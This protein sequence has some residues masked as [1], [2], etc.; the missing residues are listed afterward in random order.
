MACEY[1]SRIARKPWECRGNG[2]HR[3]RHAHAEGCTGTIKP[4][5]L[6]IELLD[7]TP[8]YHSGPRCCL[9]C[10]ERFHGIDIALEIAARAPLCSKCESPIDAAG[11][12]EECGALA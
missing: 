1:N 3:D 5:E 12:C 9:A 7:E 11:R 4:G 6:C 2:A 10:A 8:A